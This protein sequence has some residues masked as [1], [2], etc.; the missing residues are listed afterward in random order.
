MPQDPTNSETHKPRFIICDETLS[1]VKADDMIDQI[2]GIRDLS[3]IYEFI[4]SAIDPID[5][6]PTW[7]NDM[8]R[9]QLASLLR[10]VNRDFNSRL[11]A[12]ERMLEAEE[13]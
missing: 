3:N 4:Y 11:T 8:E 10:I 2:A 13:R 9:A 7:P 6:V 12:V 5:G 1:H